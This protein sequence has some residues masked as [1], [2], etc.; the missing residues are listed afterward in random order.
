VPFF[1]SSLSPVSFLKIISAFGDDLTIFSC[2]L[3]FLRN[4][5]SAFIL[6]FFSFF[7]NKR[8]GRALLPALYFAIK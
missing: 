6:S 1:V 8:F 5:L 2:F 4:S 7:F 3:N